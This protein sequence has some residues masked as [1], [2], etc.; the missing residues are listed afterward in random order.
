VQDTNQLIH[1]NCIKRKELLTAYGF[2]DSS[3]CFYSH[4]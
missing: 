2:V 4:S 3:F 1:Y